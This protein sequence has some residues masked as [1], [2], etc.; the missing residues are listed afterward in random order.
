MKLSGLI[1]IAAATSTEAF[2]LQSTKSMQ[3]RDANTKAE[4]L[5]TT[6]KAATIAASF[7]AGMSVAAGVAFADTS[8][9]Q[10]ND[11]TMSF[12]PSSSSSTTLISTS[13]T[14]PFQ[15]PSY[16]SSIKNKA[17]EIDLEAVNKDILDKAAARRDDK[18]V[19]AANNAER[20]ALKK[21]EAEEEVRLT[22]MREYAKQEREDAIAK[23]KAETK[24][25]RWNTF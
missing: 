20:I 2:S 21:M 14:D 7:F 3:L 5:A 24:A 10:L 13:S 25:N 12:A 11:P 23:E 19:D 17:I 6:T 15:L 18:N 9:T 4:V 8:T 22:R 1:L 16:E